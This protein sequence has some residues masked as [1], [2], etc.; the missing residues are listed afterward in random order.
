VARREQIARFIAAA[1]E[2]LRDKER[3]Q[4]AIDV[5]RLIELG[6]GEQLE[7]KSTLRVNLHTG[8]KDPRMELAILKSIAG[9]LNSRGGVLVIGVTDDG[10]TLGLDA[11]EFESEDRMNLHLVSLVRD[12]IGAQFL[13]YVH[14]RFE[15]RDGKR[16]LA[17]ECWAANSPVFVK[18]AGGEKFYVRTGASTTE[19]SPSQ[20]Q[21]FI[22]RRFA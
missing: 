7:L 18:E 15:D 9:F 8:Q 21:D 2:K 19:L 22:K 12:R 11:D 3:K 6:E 5:A 1:H 10:E 16:V 4:V 14:P 13:I 17:V 20:T